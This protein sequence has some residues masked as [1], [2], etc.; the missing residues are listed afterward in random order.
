MMVNLMCFLL[1]TVI[2]LFLTELVRRYSLKMNILDMPGE[3]SSHSTATPR[4]GGLSIVVIFLVVVSF[5]DLLVTNLVF[6]LIGAGILIAAVGFWD[7]HADIAAKWRLVSHFIAAAWVLYWL[8]GLPEFTLFGFSINTSWFGMLIVAFLL[9]WMLNLF[10]FMDGIDGIAASE[11]VFVTSTGA[12]ISYL[13]GVEHLSFISFVLTASTMGFLILNWSPA[14]IFMG[15]VGSGFVGLMLGIIVYVNIL[16]GSSIWP[17]LILLAVFLVDTGVTLVIRA[18]NGDK[19]YEAHCSHAYQH[20]ARKW[21]HK[22]VTL[23]VIAINI[24]LLFPLALLSQLK[25]DWG[26]L[27]TLLTFVGLIVVALKFKAGIRDM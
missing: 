13:N 21:G 22:K 20:A 17:W 6:A 12:Y 15:D 2:S 3:R 18:L 9:V 10:N 14:K 19:W 5:N 1:I 7:D 27:L 26:F 11:V 8:G 25:P 16:E 4:G 23:S 24:F